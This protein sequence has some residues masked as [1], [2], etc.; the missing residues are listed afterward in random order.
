MKRIKSAARLVREYGIDPV[1]AYGDFDR[2][3]HEQ[4]H[5]VVIVCKPEKP[6]LTQ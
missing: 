4:K 5:D 2:M 6:R 1:Q 3:L